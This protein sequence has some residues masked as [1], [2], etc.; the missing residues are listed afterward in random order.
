LSKTAL[1]ISNYL[2]IIIIIIII[3]IDMEIENMD[4]I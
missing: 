4:L 1:K 2:C 3:I